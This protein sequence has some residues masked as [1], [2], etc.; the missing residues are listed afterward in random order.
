MLGFGTR[1]NVTTFPLTAAMGASLRREYREHA[2]NCAIFT[3]LIV[4]GVLV[5]FQSRF[6][7]LRFFGWF[8][9]SISSLF[10]L[11]VGVATAGM[12][13]DLRCGIYLR[14]SGAARTD[15]LVHKGENEYF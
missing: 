15:V 1:D 2:V 5:Q 7:W 4:F 13:D 9:I 8:A 12:R 11:Y 10:L 14:R 3:L 6:F